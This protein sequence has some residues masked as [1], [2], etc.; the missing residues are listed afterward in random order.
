MTWFPDDDYDER[1]EEPREVE[2]P[3]FTL[4]QPGPCCICG[5]PGR[6]YACFSCGRPVCYNEQDY[7]AS[8]NC[9]GWIL[10]SWHPAHPEENEFYC[11]ECLVAGQIPPEGVSIAGGAALFKWMENG[12][13]QLTIN[14]QPPQVLSD[15]NS[16]DLVAYLYHGR[17][18][19]FGKR[20]DPDAP[21]ESA[22]TPVA[23]ASPL[24]GDLDELGELE[25]HPF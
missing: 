8:S 5:R 11:G 13:L 2:I 23:V 6:V 16:R 3:T 7:F 18:E 20:Y 24:D 15:E 21:E 19:L 12:A 1:D 4:D 22:P 10:D 25:G 17:G 14:G 9:G